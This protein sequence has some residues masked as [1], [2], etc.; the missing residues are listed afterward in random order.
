MPFKQC[1][2]WQILN[3]AIA[4]KHGRGPCLNEYIVLFPD[5][6]LQLMLLF[7]LIRQL[8]FLNLYGAQESM[9]RHQFRQP[10]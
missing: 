10:M 5:V 4:Q 6:D 9:P 2:L 8:V 3:I 1:A 7:F